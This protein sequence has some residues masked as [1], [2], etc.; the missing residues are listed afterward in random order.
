[1]AVHGGSWRFMAVHGGSWRFMAVHSGSMRSTNAPSTAH[2]RLWRKGG[3]ED[4]CLPLPASRRPRGWQ[5]KEWGGC[6]RGIRQFFLGPSGIRV[7]PAE[8]S[9]LAELPSHG[10]S[11]RGLRRTLRLLRWRPTGNP[12]RPF[13]FGNP[14]VR[15][16]NRM[17]WG[18]RR[19]VAG[20][21][22]RAA[23]GGPPAVRNGF[24]L[25][26]PFGWLDR[27]GALRGDRREP[28]REIEHEAEGFR[29][30]T[31]RPKRQPIHVTMLFRPRKLGCQCGGN[32]LDAG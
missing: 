10:A 7:G 21:A 17:V 18:V 27:G 32:P 23:I 3:W 11:Q 6:F 8:D 22:G 28:Q 5:G 20:K 15:L 25:A 24:E 14:Q 26:S 30:R 16:E 19:R 29:A 9:C 2:S 1:M 4:L 31:Q 12:E 13:S